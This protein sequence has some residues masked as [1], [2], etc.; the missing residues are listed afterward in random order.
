MYLNFLKMYVKL[1]FSYYILYGLDN[2]CFSEVIFFM[3]VEIY[4]KIC[5]IVKLEK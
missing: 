1:V 2:V 5:Y 3:I 4:G